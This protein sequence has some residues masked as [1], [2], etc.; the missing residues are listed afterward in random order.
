MYRSKSHKNHA[1]SYFLEHVFITICSSAA[2]HNKVVDHVYRIFI[3]S[4]YI[5][6]VREIIS[7]FQ[8]LLQPKKNFSGKS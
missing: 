5:V 4:G 7:T 2:F 8:D 3:C 6:N 1:T